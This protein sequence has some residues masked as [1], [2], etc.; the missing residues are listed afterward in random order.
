MAEKEEKKETAA[1]NPPPVRKKKRT[2]HR[3]ERHKSREEREWRTAPPAHRFGGF[4]YTIYPVPPDVDP[5]DPTILDV[6]IFATTSP[7]KTTFT[8]TYTDAGGTTYNGNPTPYDPAATPTP[9][10]P[11][12]APSGYPFIW[13]DLIPVAN[14]PSYTY[15]LVGKYT[16]PVGGAI[17]ID[18]QLAVAESA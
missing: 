17:E 12:S 1:Q 3:I 8:S 9:P 15:T 18:Y 4:D 2:L 14:Q 11:P 7:T 5:N 13:Y 16:P 10:T 6:F